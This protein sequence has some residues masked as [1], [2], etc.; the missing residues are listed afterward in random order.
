MNLAAEMGP[1]L[2][3][4]E[5]LRALIAS[6]GR[7]PIAET[8]DFRLVQV[9]DGF[10]VFEGTPSLS[11]YN[12]IGMV[13]GGYA[14]TLLDSAC[15]CAVHSKLSATQAYSTLELKVAYHKAITKDTGLL[16]AEG[17]V[18]SFGRRAGFSEAKLTDS[19]GKLYAS[20]TSTLIVMER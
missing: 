5:Q 18:L 9:D 4:L 10:A 20:A 2:T 16:R 13:H 14:A 7:P 1:G 6:G 19:A 12:P 11:V 3:G 8:L 17:R 15:G